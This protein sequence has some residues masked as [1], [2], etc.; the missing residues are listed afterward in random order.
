MVRLFKRFFSNVYILDEF[1]TSISCIL[2]HSRSKNIKSDKVVG[3]TKGG[4]DIKRKVHKILRC[5]NEN[6]RI[7]VNR[8]VAGSSNQEE[9]SYRIINS[10]ELDPV[11]DRATKLAG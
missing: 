10:I 5:T 3:V 4:N 6:C 7:I 11:F 8:D 1:R 9:N 2:C